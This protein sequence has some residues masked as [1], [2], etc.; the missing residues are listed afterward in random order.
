MPRSDHYAESLP[1]GCG[2][3]CPTC[4]VPGYQNHFYEIHFLTGC[5]PNCL[6]LEIDSP[7]DF[8]QGCQIRSVR[9]YRN[10]SGTDFPTD[11]SLE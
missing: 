11:F 5:A 6:C 9:N 8:L 7:N 3:G 1:T 4:C 2:L 10:D